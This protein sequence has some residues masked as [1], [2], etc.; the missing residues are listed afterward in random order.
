MTL[1]LTIKIAAAV[2]LIFI[3]LM[4]SSNEV[5]FVYKGF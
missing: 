5:D 2:G 3:L 1:R 4:F